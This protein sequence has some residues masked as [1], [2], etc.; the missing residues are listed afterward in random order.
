MP[1]ATQGPA[2]DV[3]PHPRDGAALPLARAPRDRLA[4][5]PGHA[6]DPGRRDRRAGPAP[7]R[8]GARRRRARRPHLGLPRL[9]AARAVARVGR[10][11]RSPRVVRRP[12]LL[13]APRAGVRRPGRG[14]RGGPRRRPRPRGE[15]HQPHGPD[16]HRRPQR[17]LAVRRPA[18]R[19][20]RRASRPACTRATA[21][22]C[23]G[24]A[25]SR[26]CAAPRRRTSRRPPRRRPAP[27]GWTATSSSRR[28]G[29]ARCWRW[30]RSPGTR[31]SAPPAAAGWDVPR[32]KPRFGH[33]AEVASRTPYGVVRLVGSYHVSQQNTFTGKLTEAMLDEVVARL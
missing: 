6:R 33:G 9:P 31:R 11:D 14:G 5:G 28:R 10:D 32:P 3:R 2:G 25:S 17:R 21:S 27:R 1:Q 13:G 22:G 29:C 4:G 12:A 18:P 16:V 26:P 24:C 30:A 19:R 7:R 15:R 23:A 20:V 8:V